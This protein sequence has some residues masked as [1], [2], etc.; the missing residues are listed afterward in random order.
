M[1]PPLLRRHD[2]LQPGRNDPGRQLGP[3]VIEVDQ[4]I[5]IF[6]IGGHF[7]GQVDDHDLIFPA[8]FPDSVVEG[9]IH[10]FEFLVADAVVA[11]V[12]ADGAAHDQELVYLDDGAT[13]LPAVEVIGDVAHQYFWV[14][15]GAN[16]NGVSDNSNR[17]GEF[18][19]ALV[20][21]Q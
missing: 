8:H 4:V 9:V 15:R 13:P 1:G 19:F 2:P 6:F 7:P 11:A 17:V 21:G 12:A 18:D 10:L 3:G 20:P 14:V 5:Q 16:D